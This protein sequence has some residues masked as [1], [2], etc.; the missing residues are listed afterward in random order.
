[1]MYSELKAYVD[2]FYS[3]RSRSAAETREALEELRDDLDIL[4][5]TLAEDED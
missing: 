4:I 2:R 1:M 5:E 3:D